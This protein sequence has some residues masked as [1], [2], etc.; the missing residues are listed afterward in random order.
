MSTAVIECKPL[1]R[2]GTMRLTVEPRRAETAQVAG[3]E[4]KLEDETV[5]DW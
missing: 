1:L 3:L 2:T 4:R 5:D